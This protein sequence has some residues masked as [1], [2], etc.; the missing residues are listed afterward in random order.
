MWKYILY[1]YVVNVE[2]CAM[3]AASVG[4]L[5]LR[6][7]ARLDAKWLKIDP[8]VRNEFYKQLV[9]CYVLNY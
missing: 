9:L 3:A 8:Q 1:S 5:K 7:Q 4:D 6:P 2:A